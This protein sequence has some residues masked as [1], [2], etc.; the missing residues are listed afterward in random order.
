MTCRKLCGSLFPYPFEISIG[1]GIGCRGRRQLTQGFR[2]RAKGLGGRYAPHPTIHGALHTS[3]SKLAMLRWAS[4]RMLVKQHI[5]LNHLQSEIR[6]ANTGSQ[7][8]SQ[9]PFLSP[10]ERK[11]AS[12]ALVGETNFACLPFPKLGVL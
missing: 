3:L 12:M 10:S 4:P 6:M 1:R 2:K 11:E 5:G 9:N 7:S 8:S